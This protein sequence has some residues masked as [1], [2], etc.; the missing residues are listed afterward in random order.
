MGFAGL[1]VPAG[2]ALAFVILTTAANAIVRPLHDRMPVLL[3][4]STVEPWLSR[5]DASVRAPAPDGWLAARE[6]SLLVNS[7]ANDG[8][9]LLEA[10]PPGRQLELV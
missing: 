4:D 2:D 5:G 8:P 6:V 9:E 1:A 10:A 7:P 3:S